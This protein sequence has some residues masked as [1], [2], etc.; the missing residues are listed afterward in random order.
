MGIKQFSG[1][2]LQ[3]EDRLLFRLN[4]TDELEYR[5]L[6]T[7]HITR[8]LLSANLKQLTGLVSL[9]HPGAT[10]D[11]VVRFKQEALRQNT[12]LAR[13]FTPATER[14]LGEQPV[15]VLDA[16]HTLDINSAA[17]RALMQ[18]RLANKPDA[19]FYLPLESLHRM[20]LL[21][22]ELQQRASWNLRHEPDHSTSAV[23]ARSSSELH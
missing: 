2:Y 1:R 9:Q 8:K 18:F 22:D 20:Q 10:S 13:P 3:R 7:R 23:P 21:L 6:L 14:P 5:F 12:D 19:V 17:P 15:L 4:T 11:A 16:S